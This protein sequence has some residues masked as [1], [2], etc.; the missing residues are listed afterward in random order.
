MKPVESV[1]K[2]TANLPANLLASATRITGKGVTPT[3]VEGLLE[4]E[5]REKR[6]ALRR[7]KGKVHFALDLAA[8]RR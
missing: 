7:L 4:I 3:L 2:V 8:T 6:S 5:R 1:R